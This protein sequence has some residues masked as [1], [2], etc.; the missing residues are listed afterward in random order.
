MSSAYLNPAAFLWI[1]LVVVMLV[2]KLAPEIY[3]VIIVKMTEKWY[4]EVIS[5]LAP[6]SRVLDVGIGTGSALARNAKAIADKDLRFVGVDYED[7]YVKKCARV[8]KQH[9]LSDSVSAVCASVYDARLEEYVGREFDAVYF[10]GSISLMPDPVGALH[11]SAKLLKPNGR[12]YVTQTF[13]RRGTAVFARIK[14]LLKYVTT[15]DFGKLTYETEFDALC[16]QSGM[17]VLEKSLI[18]GSVDNYFQGAF[19]IVLKP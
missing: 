19:V 11:A 6:K 5:R 1:S 18:P 16:R 17:K 9:A 8:M 14:P 12:I 4:A 10:S 3:D 15:I 7:A 13:Q 2:Q